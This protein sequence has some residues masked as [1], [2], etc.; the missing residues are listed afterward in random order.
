MHDNC[1]RARVAIDVPH[2]VPDVLPSLTPALHI[3][4][5]RTVLLGSLIAKHYGLPFHIRLDGNY[6]GETSR[7]G[8]VLMPLCTIISRL[9]IE[10][11]KVYWYSQEAPSACQYEAHFGDRGAEIA[12]LLDALCEYDPVRISAFTDDLMRYWP[13]LMIRGSEFA[14]TSQAVQPNNSG[15]AGLVRFTAKE[16]LI[17][18]AM[19]REPH[20]INVPLITSDGAKVSKSLSPTL[21]WDLFERY[22]G[23]WVRRFL[24][25]TAMK[26]DAPLKALGK[27]FAL[28][29]MSPMP[30]EWDWATWDQ[31]IR[32]CEAQG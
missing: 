3:G 12:R 9:G 24:L 7:H 30:Y 27:R 23:Q 22:P 1:K 10:C 15:V 4:H 32:D 16:T 13:S 11:D 21:M 18:E 5:A 2:E 17:S 26:P 25:A 29:E 8:A 20:E 31:Y 14:D 28:E 6:R 19:G